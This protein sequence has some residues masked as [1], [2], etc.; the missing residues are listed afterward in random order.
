MPA[1]AAATAHPAFPPSFGDL[2]RVFLHI[3]LLS[4]GGP[5]AQIALMHRVLVDE[6]NWLSEDDFLRALSFC[7]LLPGPE[8]MQHATDAGWK[9]RGT[10]GGLIAGLLFVGPGAV[11]VL[12]LAIFYALHGEAPVA[13]ALLLGV[14]AAVAAIVL[15][16][17]IRLGRR[18]LRDRSDLGI[19]VIAFAALFLFN[20]PFPV[21]IAGAALFGWWRGRTAPCVPADAPLPALSATIRT[22]A[23]WGTIWLVPLILL[24]LGGHD[25]LTALGLYFSTLA[26]VTFGGAYAALGW[27]TQTVVTEFGWITQSQMMDALGLAETT[28]G[29][30]IL[31]TQFV[32]FL[33]AFRQGGLGLG[34][35]GAAVALWMTFAPCFLWIFAGAP[36]L[37]HLTRRPGLQGALAAISAAAVGVIGS[38]SVWF[39]LHVLFS[40]VGSAGSGWL[41]VPVPDMSSIQITAAGL[42]VAAGIMIFGARWPVPLVLALCALGSWGVSVI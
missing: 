2:F 1:R 38:I 24:H 40:R 35:A 5:A 21:L 20:L 25:H 32:G 26:V 30:L 11:V 28:P 22:A 34:L 37:D 27:M 23:L 19:A 15:Q 17:M 13:Q 14:K 12:I 6:R 3:G 4:F 9:L 10:A 18:A 39:A 41:S 16:A 7:M 8:A 33:A 29:P 31:V 42:T 36:W